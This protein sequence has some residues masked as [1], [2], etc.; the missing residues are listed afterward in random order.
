MRVFKYHS[1]TDC[2]RFLRQTLL[3]CTNFSNPKDFKAK[4]ESQDL[5]ALLTS[6]G[7]AATADAAMKAVSDLGE[8][9]LTG[10]GVVKA[11]TKLRFLLRRRS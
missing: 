9:L 4:I 3:K 5:C 7:E 11:D 1:L 2:H 8:G 10:L 6:S